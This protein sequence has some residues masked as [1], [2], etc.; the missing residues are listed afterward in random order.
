MKGK[1][2]ACYN[3]LRDFF[4]KEYFSVREYVVIC[5]LSLIIEL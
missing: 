2:S 5:F 4:E 3:G 1:N